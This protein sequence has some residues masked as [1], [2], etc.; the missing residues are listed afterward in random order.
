MMLCPSFLKAETQ[1]VPSL[2]SHYHCKFKMFTYKNRLCK[3]ILNI[4]LAEIID[5]IF[6]LLC[7]LRYVLMFVLWLELESIFAKQELS[8]AI[9]FL[10]FAL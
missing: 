6:F 9:L 3:T 7:T 4:F 1:L 2:Q 5:L 10:F 8:L